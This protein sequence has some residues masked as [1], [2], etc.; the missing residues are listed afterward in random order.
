[1]KC[2]IGNVELSLDCEPVFDYGRTEARWEYSGQG[3]RRRSPT[4]ARATSSCGWSPTSGSGSRAGRPA[5]VPP[6][7]G[8]RAFAALCWPRSQWSAS[9]EYWAERAPRPTP[10]RRSSAWSGR[11]S[12]A[13]LDQPGVFPEHPGGAYLQRGALTLKGLTYAP[14][15]ALLA[16]ATTSLPETPD[17]ERNYDYRYTWIRDATFMLWG[18]YTLGF[19]R[20]ANDFFYFVADV[21]SGGGQLQIMYGVGGEKELPEQELDHLNG[22]EDAEPVR[23]GNAAAA[24]RQ[25]TS[26]GPCSTRSTC[27]PSPGTTCPSGCGRCSSGPSSRHR[28]LEQARPGDLGGP[29]AAT[30]LHLLQADVLGGL[31]PGARLA[32][33]HGDRDLAATWRKAAEEIHADICERGVDERGVFVQHYDTTALDASVLLMPLL[34]FL[35]R[36]P[37]DPRHRAG[38]RRRADRGRAGAALPGRGDRRRLRR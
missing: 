26:G 5:P 3:Y 24:Q 23:I 30:A 11:P 38:H 36:R 9:E 35:P 16:A 21:C 18:L 20:E 22:Y 14:T 1:M 7:E 37:A 32:K 8:D 12:S 31:R 13:G 29:G 33:L 34:R 15:G 6:G 4:A 19:E 10:R 2:I 27:A 28:Q 17:G 25:P